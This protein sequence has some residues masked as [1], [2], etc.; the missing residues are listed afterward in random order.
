MNLKNRHITLLL[1][2]VTFFT[3]EIKSQNPVLKY[4]FRQIAGTDSVWDETGNSNNAL[5]VGNA[6]VKTLGK[7]G[8]LSIEN[9]TG[10][11]NMTSKVGNI[12]NQLNDFTVTTYL[13]IDPSLNLSNNGNFV[14]TFSNS[15]DI[16]KTANG[17]MFYTVK[18]SRYA[19]CNTNYKTEKTVNLG[20]ES[21]KGS[22]KHVAYTQVGN[23][24]SIYIDGILK[25]TGTISMLPSDLGKTPYNYLCK[26][27]YASDQV[28][29]NSMLHDF[30]I[31]NVSLSSA[32]ISQLAAN[33]S[34][35]DTAMYK[36]IVDTALVKLDLGDLNG[37]TSNLTLP[38]SGY[39][40]TQIRWNSSN[41]SIISSSGVVNRPTYG[42][43]NV[44]VTL[45][46]T[47]TKDFVSQTVTFEATVLSSISDAKSVNIDSDNLT[48]GGNLTNLRS[49][50]YLPTIGEE[51]SS[52]S[53]ISDNP[54]ILSNSGEIIN[55]PLH[56][57]GNAKVILTATITKGNETVT[58]IFEVYVAEDEGFAGYLFAYFTGNS[59][60]QEAIRFA[61]SDDGYTYKAL[62]DNAPILNSADI[63]STG[64]VRD[65]HILRGGGNEYYM[66]VTDMVSAWGWDS[67]R[68]M[69][70]LKSNNLTDWQSS[71]VNIPQ[72]YPQ[73][74]AADRI[75]APQ[76]IY[77]P[78]VKKYM[79]YFSMRLGPGDSDKIY[80][81]YANDR[82]LGF[83]SAPQLLFDNNGLSTIDADI[84]F[85]DGKYQ[86]FFKTEGNGNGIK[87]AVSDS[88][89][90]GYVLHDKYLQST[91]NA[92]EGG[93]VYRMYNSD[94]WM[95]IYDMYSSGA[96]QFTESTDLIDF[97]ITSRLVSF[98]FAPR[99][100]TIIPITQ[101]EKTTLN[102]KWGGS[103]VKSNQQVVDVDVF[104]NPTSDFI[105][106][107]LDGNIIISGLEINIVDVTGKIIQT[108]QL[109][110]NSKK[111]DV[112]NLRSGIYFIQIESDDTQIP[113]KIFMKR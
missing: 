1:L 23:T 50:L 98:D 72:L 56:K 66:V 8:V 44:V 90:G 84:V 70:L 74:A 64:G 25:K 21:E 2:L 58:K 27:S 22:W 63:S 95:L 7:F 55:F 94:T 105:N 16:N 71:V 68:A 59:G 79:V 57:G 24:G 112:R 73:Y 19:I 39:G 67:N 82:F 51:G 40:D 47:V 93:C 20:T 37:I 88:L 31:Y 3:H 30:R 53:W 15:S 28:L 109:S 54:S 5:L 102:A 104:P 46:A 32:Q 29:L 92:V 85:F 38:I 76:T 34:A 45:T 113:S 78:I 36:D 12:I 41:S 91:T 35:L 99:H 43:P 106:V 9:E 6:Q 69:V 52:I 87:K 60:N 42:T 81:A 4:G 61:L 96:Y 49:D 89:T 107:W 83:E 101:Q 97:S 100:G 86:M 62:N 103:G 77:D 75:W 14:W 48:L 17:C 18:N 13:Y 80:Y 65:P 10:Y 11:V 26:S 108:Q 33:K 110:G 111:I